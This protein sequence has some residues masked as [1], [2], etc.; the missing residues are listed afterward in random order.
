MSD[1]YVE[2][3]DGP[4]RIVSRPGRGEATGLGGKWIVRTREPASWEGIWADV[5]QGVWDGRLGQAAKTPTEMND[6][7]QGTPVIIYTDDWNDVGE[8]T[9]VLGEL[10]DMGIE[11]QLIYKADWT[12][13]ALINGKGVSS[14]VAKA[15][16]RVAEDRRANPLKR[17]A[18]IRVVRDG[19][20]WQ[21]PNGQVQLAFQAWADV[22]DECGAC[23][24]DQHEAC[25]DAHLLDGES[26]GV[27]EATCSCACWVGT[28][29]APAAFPR[30]PGAGA[31]STE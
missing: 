19:D 16:S 17:L 5:K 9:R 18:E 20:G 21:P 28:L 3:I 26:L 6:G 4:W 8:V 31:A 14:Y 7:P 23:V 13:G 12:T 15:G 11:S 30:R 29:F 10:R 22:L 27:N 25:A 1:K 2:E 24:A